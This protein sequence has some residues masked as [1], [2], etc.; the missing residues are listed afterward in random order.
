VVAQ[1]AGGQLPIR[2]LADAAAPPV[3]YVVG[4]RDTD[5]LDV[6]PGRPGPLGEPPQVRAVSAEVTGDPAAPWM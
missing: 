5:E 1:P 2:L 6:D 3:E 4:V